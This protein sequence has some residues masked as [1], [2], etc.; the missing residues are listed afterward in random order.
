MI[1]MP[2]AWF[3]LVFIII[4][5]GSLWLVYRYAHDK[6]ITDFSALLFKSGYDNKVAAFNEQNK[7]VDKGGISFVG[8]S[9]TQDYAVHEYFFGREVY[10]RGIGG[11]TTEGVL[12]RLEESVFALSPK[13][14]VLL[15]G[16]N[17]YSVLGSDNDVIEANI[18]RIITSIKKR[19]PDC[20]IIL[21]SVYPVNKS[22]DPMSVGVRSNKT[23]NTL[24][25]RL[26]TLKDVTYIDVA[27]HLKDEEGNLDDTYTVEGLHLNQNGYRIVTKVLKERL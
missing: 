12:K 8:D 16:T 26:A 14:V 4:Y 2:D 24:N 19:L 17:D 10:N 3:L 25:E 1:R 18:K 23:I 22:L 7:W 27:S 9:I 15:I 6:G 21:E 5:T 13:T 11:D 20:R